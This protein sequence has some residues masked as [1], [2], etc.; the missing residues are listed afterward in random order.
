MRF[1]DP[2]WLFGTLLAVAVA[3]LLVVGG[4]LLLRSIRRFG[5]E[6]RVLD[7]VTA[8]ASTRRVIQGLLTVIAVACAFVAMSRPQY[9]RGTRLVPATNL[10]VVVALDYSKSMYA[11]DVSPSRTL[12]AKSEVSRLISELRGARFGAVAFAGE[13]MT[14]PLTSDGAAIAQFFRQLTPND[15]PVGGTSLARAIA[16]G[17]ELFLRDPSTQKHAKVLVLVTDGEDLEGDPAAMAQAAHQDGI[18]V[19]V[20][21]IGGRSPE[22]IP[23]IDDT[24]K[25]RGWRKD[26][27]GNPLTTSLSSE[28]EAQLAETANP[29]AP[30]RDNFRGFAR[31]APEF[32]VCRIRGC[33]TLR[34][35]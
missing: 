16:A 33:G 8:R 11:R 23:E 29:D 28:G 2:F 5:D 15:M 19:D 1:A 14:F 7:L 30:Y 9:G 35:S 31:I 21:Q 12:R 17:H 32:A 20:V 24:G 6:A 22:P 10:D 26:S 34:F 25:L 3:L 13:P 18:T 27:Q 4:W